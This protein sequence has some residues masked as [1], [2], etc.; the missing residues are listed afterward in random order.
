[1]ADIRV[2]ATRGGDK[3]QTSLVDGTR[4]SKGA[5]RVRTYGCVDE[6]NSVLGLVRCE[7]LPGQLD[8]HLAQIQNDLF[9]IGSELATPLDSDAYGMIQTATE[10]H[11]EILEGW[12]SETLDQIEECKSFILPGGTRA[13]ASLHLART[14][15]RRCERD[16]V[17]LIETEEVNPF[18]LKYINRL[19]D[20]CFVWARLCN[21]KGKA[22]VLWLPEKK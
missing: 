21:N 7:E 9:S 2:V 13:A 19:S 4:V 18:C 16:L 3:G 14:V 8:D 22:D 11:V 12:I 10:A 20:L 1:M 15:A 6:L 5:L 17:T